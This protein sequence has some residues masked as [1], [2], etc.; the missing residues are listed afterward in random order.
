MLTGGLDFP[1]DCRHIG[2]DQVLKPGIGVKVA[3][4]AA[5]AAKGD[6]DV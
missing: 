1:A 5:G 6:V 3:V 4:G 2:G